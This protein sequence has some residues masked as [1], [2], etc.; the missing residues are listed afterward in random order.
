MLIRLSGRPD[1]DVGVGGG[2]GWER[3]TTESL[4]GVRSFAGGE[5]SWLES[6]GGG[7]KEY[8][9]VRIGDVVDVEE[10][11]VPQ[12][13]G[14]CSLEVEVVVVDDPTEDEQEEDLR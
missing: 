12:E 3:L 11:E 9:T 14:R 1:G 10:V 13:S 7:R 5:Y 6:T 8:I 4:C 2:G